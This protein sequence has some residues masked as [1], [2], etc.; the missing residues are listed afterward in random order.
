MFGLRQLFYP[1]GFVV[2]AVALV[3]FARRR[4]E[5]YWLYVIL[6]GGFVG[7][8]AYI[9]VEVLRT[10]DCFAA[11]FKDS[12]ADRASRLWKYKF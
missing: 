4:P 6:F 5:G 3:H 7:A 9:V 12:G 2:Q 10:R 1:W 8:S 11:C